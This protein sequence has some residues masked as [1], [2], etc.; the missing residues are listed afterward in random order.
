M[1]KNQTTLYESTD[2]IG[3]GLLNALQE[4]IGS[5]GL[6]D[7]LN[8]AG[9]PHLSANLPSLKPAIALDNENISHIQLAL[10]EIYGIQCGHGLAI[11]SGRAFFNQFL[12]A[13]A[14]DYGLND[15]AFRLLPLRRKTFTGL[16]KLA[17]IFNQHS[18][19]HITV[20]QAEHFYWRV[21]SCPLC[22]ERRATQPICYL[23][24]GFLQEVMYWISAGHQYRVEETACIAMGDPACNFR[25]LSRPIE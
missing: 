6:L 21:E 1:I 16:T 13:Y 12:R 20:E 15:T 23:T 17:H 14:G 11:R 8:H 7:L 24:I 10:G 4:I 5:Q 18:H 9:Q 3:Q 25:I 19:Q 2:L 22:W